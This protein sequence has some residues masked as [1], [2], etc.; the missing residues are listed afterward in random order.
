MK[1]KAVI[2]ESG[3]E[4]TA[5]SC[6]GNPVHPNKEIADA[7][8]KVHEATVLLAEK[9]G[10]S[11]V[12]GFSGCPGANPDAT[13]PAWNVVAWPDDFAK[14]LQWQWDEIL[15]P[16]WQKQAEF[17]EQHNVKIAFEPH[18]GFCVY[19][20]ETMLKIRDACGKVIGCNLD[21]SHLFWQGMDPLKIVRKLKDAIFHVHAKDVKID[22]TNTE[23]NGVL[24]SKSYGDEI[25]RSWIFRSVGYGHEI[26]WWKAFVPELRMN[27][28]DNVLSIE[29]EDSLMAGDER[30]EKSICRAERSDNLEKTRAD[31]P[32][33]K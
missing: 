11:T 33:P 7:H 28:Y 3:L 6:H 16:F 21:P 14:S 29:H 18:P 25:N 22:P 19:N 9:L 15:I 4:V 17:A 27:G 12:I 13:T 32:G 20:A 5:L 26:S 31:D 8:L 23:L 24:D 10:I 2:D 1:F 30:L